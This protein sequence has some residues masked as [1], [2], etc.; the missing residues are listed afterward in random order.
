MHTYLCQEL[1]ESQ[2]ELVEP[3][4]SPLY[5]HHTLLCRLEINFHI[6]YHASTVTEYGNINLQELCLERLSSWLKSS[7]QIDKL[8]LPTT[9]KDKL[10]RYFD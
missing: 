6:I 10:K 1:Y 3:S 9:L 2:L 5:P 4:L 7:D 8:P